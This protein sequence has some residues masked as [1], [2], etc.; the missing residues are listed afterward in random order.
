[1]P[2]YLPTSISF[3]V[4][5]S[6][7][8]ICPPFSE[9]PPPPVVYSR[10]ADDAL[11]SL[12]SRLKER[13]KVLKEKATDPYTTSPEI[14]PPVSKYGHVS[15]KIKT[16]HEGR[17]TRRPSLRLVSTHPEEAGLHQAEGRGADCQGRGWEK[18]GRGGSQK[19]RGEEEEGR[20]KK[21]GGREEGRGGEVGRGSEE[22]GQDP[23]GH[24]L[25]L[26]RRPLPTHRERNGWRPGEH[27][28]PFRWE[29]CK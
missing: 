5:L 3:I 6:R 16:G 10:V 1:M 27:H 25:L 28:R 4:L 18:E 2:S 15:A 19:G 7:L 9:P 23:P 20:G 11:R 26:F 29:N 24:Q 14:T 17:L 8:L 22:N 12:I 21:A 13:T